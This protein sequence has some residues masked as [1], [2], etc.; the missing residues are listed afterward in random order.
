MPSRIISSPEFMALR[1]PRAWFWG[2]FLYIL[3]QEW[4]Y[5]NQECS[6]LATVR[7]EGQNVFISL[8]TSNRI[9]AVPVIRSIQEESPVT[10][11]WMAQV[12]L[13]QMKW[14]CPFKSLLRHSASNFLTDFVSSFC[15]SH[16]IILICKM[17]RP[18]LVKVLFFGGEVILVSAVQIFLA[19]CLHVELSVGI[20]LIA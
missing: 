6:F 4:T 2:N 11:V 5:E 12:S 20:Y 17:I 7:W 14:W 18:T 16:F 3:W 13:Q 10:Q 19:A 15:W 9:L 1:R 8:L